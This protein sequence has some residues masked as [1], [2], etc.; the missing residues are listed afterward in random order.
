MSA[1]FA[2]LAGAMVVGN[3]KNLIMILPIFL[4]S[5]WEQECSGSDGLVLMQVLLWRQC[6]G[7]NGFRNYNNCFSFRDDDVDLFRQN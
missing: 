4:M 2:A 7:S 3:R 5:C 1:G 6:N